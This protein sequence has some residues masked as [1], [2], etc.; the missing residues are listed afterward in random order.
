MEWRKETV[1]FLLISEMVEIL[2][3]AGSNGGEGWGL[4]VSLLSSTSSEAVVTSPQVS[5]VV[6]L[7]PRRLAPIS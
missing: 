7:M 3:K 5:Q 4:A 6:T 1:V 2:Y